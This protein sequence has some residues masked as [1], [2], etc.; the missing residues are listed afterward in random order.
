MEPRDGHGPVGDRA[1]VSDNESAWVVYRGLEEYGAAGDVD[2]D[3]ADP[4]GVVGAE[5]ECRVGD[6][7]G[8]P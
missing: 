7:F 3:A 5:E 4:C 6:V 1:R 8:R 2:H